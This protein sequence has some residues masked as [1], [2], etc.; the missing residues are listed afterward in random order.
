MCL[1][2]A[3]LSAIVIAHLL[4]KQRQLLSS[5]SFL[6]L[7][8]YFRFI[9]Y[10]I[11]YG[12]IVVIIMIC[13]VVKLWKK[14]KNRKKN[15]AAFSTIGTVNSVSFVIILLRIRVFYVFGKRNA[16]SVKRVK[17]KISNEMKWVG[18][19][20]FRNKCLFWPLHTYF[21][22]FFML[23]PQRQSVCNC[24]MV[25]CFFLCFSIYFTLMFQIHW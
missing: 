2:N 20:S 8:L 4:R 6:L 22:I 14:N 17:E 24:E 13:G 25:L 23:Q 12:V 16:Q 11:V 10:M 3:K 7:L 9:F 21:H 15:A 18:S 19:L 5:I 1:L